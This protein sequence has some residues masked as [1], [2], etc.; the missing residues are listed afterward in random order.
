MLTYNSDSTS[1][2]SP[3]GLARNG[4]GAL[5]LIGLSTAQCFQRAGVIRIEGVR[6]KLARGERGDFIA[7]I[8]RQKDH[9]ERIL[10]IAPLNVFIRELQADVS[11]N[12]L[13]YSKQLQSIERN[14]H[15]GQ[16]TLH[17]TDNTSHECDIL[18]GSD[19][20]YSTVRRFI[21]GDDNV[22]TKPRNTGDWA[23]ITDKPA[24][25]TRKV[26]GDQLVEEPR[27]CP[28]VG[29]GA[30]FEHNK[31]SFDFEKET[32]HFVLAS[33]DKDAV[34]SE[35]KD[36]TVTADELIDLY[37]EWPSHIDRA[38]NEVCGLLKDVIR[39]QDILL[40]SLAQ[41]LCDE[42]DQK[43]M[44]LW[45]HPP[46]HT[47]VSGP[48]CIVGE[49]AHAT[50]PWQGAS[51]G[52]MVEDV[53]IISTLLG[54]ARSK[55]DA[56]TA[57]RIYDEVRR[58]RTQM[59]AESSRRNGKIATGRDEEFGLDLKVLREKL[60]ARWYP[61]V[62]FDNEKHRDEAIQRF[63]AELERNHRS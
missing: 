29:D 13:H 18:I 19:G 11:S 34:G 44:Y 40:T 41:L 5:D 1:T 28:W 50:V 20:M 14:E 52:M 21:L 49:A 10:H 43:A 45:E 59:V 16:V 37:K 30:F 22:A 27:E 57:L 3:I 46:A 25:A 38:V 54:R 6:F 55:A 63:E 47:Y 35:K 58:P 26:F 42:G 61:I 8:D 32:V 15:S 51:A 4:L 48:V 2:N 60:L 39:P 31:W 17:F 33:H 53:M 62:N 24:A 23:I 9:D 7:E 36:R 56:L 12:R